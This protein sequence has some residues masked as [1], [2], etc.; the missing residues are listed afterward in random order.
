MKILFQVKGMSCAAC[1]ATVE[2]VTLQVEGVSRAEVNLLSGTMQVEADSE[3]VIT[4]IIQAISKAGYNAATDK[5]K[6]KDNKPETDP[7]ASQMK[8][9]FIWSA[10]FLAVLMYFTMGHMLK[11]P[12]PSWYHGTEDTLV[13]VI[14]QLLLT[15]PIVYLNRSYYKKGIRSLLHRSPNMDTLIAV[16]SGSALIYSI[17]VM[18]RLAK[19]FGEMDLITIYQYKGHLYFE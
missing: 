5:N 1:S 15:I 4:P 8:K 12:L 3:A 6:E 17:F 16:G 14:F 7:E 18:F 9:R 10:L 13:A 19:A 2:R 11:L